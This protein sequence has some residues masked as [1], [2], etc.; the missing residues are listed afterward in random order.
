ME[1]DKDNIETIANNFGLG[2]GLITNLV[3]SEAVTKKAFLDTIKFSEL[4]KAEQK[5]GNMLYSIATKLPLTA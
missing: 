5:V 4:E 1:G 3:K 2:K